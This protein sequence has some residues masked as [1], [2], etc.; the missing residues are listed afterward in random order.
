MQKL[1][2][3][4]S[5]EYSAW[6]NANRAKLA[7]FSIY[8]KGAAI[9]NAAIALSA[10]AAPSEQDEC[11]ACHGSGEHMVL[12]GGGPDAYEIPAN[13]PHCNGSGGL[14]DA[15]NGVVALHARAEQMYLEACGKLSMEKYA[16]LQAQL[17]AAAPAAVEGE[18]PPPDV[19]AYE[20]HGPADSYSKPAM[21][22]AIRAA[23]AIEREACAQICEIQAQEPECP[24][25]AQYCADA[26]RNRK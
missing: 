17:S 22:R 24:E 13:C 23:V 6:W 15:Y 18:L 19:T 4:S 2:Y 11:P 8:S 9:W 26:I 14:L 12:S 21:Q 5:P 20:P 7:N 16:P 25:R 10:P 3:Q 1:N